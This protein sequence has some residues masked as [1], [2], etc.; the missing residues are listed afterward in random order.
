[1]DETAS[2]KKKKKNPNRETA[3][4]KKKMIKTD[5]QMQIWADS[6][7]QFMQREG[8]KTSQPINPYSHT[9]TNITDEVQCSQ[10]CDFKSRNHQWNKQTINRETDGVPTRN[11]FGNYQPR[12]GAPGLINFHSTTC[13]QGCSGSWPTR[14]DSRRAPLNGVKV[15][16]DQPNWLSFGAQAKQSKESAKPFDYWFSHWPSTRNPSD[17]KRPQ[18]KKKE[19]TNWPFR[20]KVKSSSKDNKQE[21]TSPWCNH[22][23]VNEQMAQDQQGPG[24]S[25]RT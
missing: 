20:P 9:C 16:P 10:R 24:L 5:R 4:L 23:A 13:S 25:T 21:I 15:I 12:S 3:K 8:C 11:I 17:S 14:W 7:K 22:Q 19:P 2:L 18:F 1:M 6:R